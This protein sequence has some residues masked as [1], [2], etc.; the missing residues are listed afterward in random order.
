MDTTT[1][2]LLVLAIG[3]AGAVLVF[4]FR[5]SRTF[6]WNSFIDRAPRALFE[7]W[8]QHAALMLSVT[9]ILVFAILGQQ[10]FP[11][12]PGSNIIWEIC[13]LAFLLGG[14]VLVAALLV[15]CGSFAKQMDASPSGLS[16]VDRQRAFDTARYAR[17]T[18]IDAALRDQDE[19]GEL[20]PEFDE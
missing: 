3:L 4:F 13:N 12:G 11:L 15:F 1:L 6:P 2:S 10:L 8:T 9:L 16:V 7:A 18:Q 14:L 20:I 5:W 19:G 17:A